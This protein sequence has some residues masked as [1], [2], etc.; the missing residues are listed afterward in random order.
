V[1]RGVT[2]QHRP[3]G[4]RRGDSRS[5]PASRDAIL[6]MLDEFHQQHLNVTVDTKATSSGEMFSSIQAQVAAGNPPDLAQLVL[7]EWDLN[8]ENLPVKPLTDL[9]APDELQAHLQ[10]TYPMHPKAVKLTER[11]TKLQ[12]LAYVFT[13]PTLFYN[14]DLFKAALA[15]LPI[16]ALYVALQRQVIDAFIRSGLK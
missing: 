5:S 1:H 10:N 11:N 7:R 8:V 4:I 9:I 13:T 15:T 3:S 14:A 12:G 16:F 6:R 2:S